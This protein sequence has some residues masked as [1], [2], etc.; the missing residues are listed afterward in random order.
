MQ[1]LLR[2]VCRVLAL[3]F[4]QKMH[5][6]DRW[7]IPLWKIRVF[8]LVRWM[9]FLL[10]LAGVAGEGA[11]GWWVGGGWVVVRESGGG[12]WWWWVVGDVGR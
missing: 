2:L 9:L 12:C 11:G 1:S 3:H 10:H 5:N 8:R 7:F 4:I 6:L